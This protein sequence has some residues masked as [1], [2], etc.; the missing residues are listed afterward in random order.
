MALRHLLCV[1]LRVL[2]HLR[3]GIR[4]NWAIPSKRSLNWLA[5]S[6]LCAGFLTAPASQSFAQLVQLVQVDPSEVTAIDSSRRIVLQ[7]NV[8]P[9]LTAARDLGPVD[10]ALPLDHMLLQL[11]RSPARQAALDAYVAGL[12]DKSSANYHRWLTPAEFGQRF[13]AAQEDVDRVTAWLALHGFSVNAVLPNRMVIDFSGNAG[14]VR[15]AFRTGMHA[16]RYGGVRHVANAADPSIPAA[17]AGAVAGIVS[18]HDFAPRPML[19]PRK[20][21]GSIGQR[22]HGQFTTS[23]YG[24]AEYAVTPA[25]LA[26]IYNLTPLFQAGWTGK[27]QTIAI[28]GNSDVYRAA[29]WT[30]FRSTFGLAGYTSGAFRQIHPAPAARGASCADPGAIPGWDEEPIL[31]AEYATAAAPGATVEVVSC[32]STRATNGNLIALVNLVNSAGALPSVLSVSYGNCEAAN[33]VAA[34]VAIA[35][36]YQQAAAEGISVFAAAGD[37]GAAFCDV[38]GSVATHGIGVNAWASTPY[39]VAVGG[40][41]FADTSSNTLGKYWNRSNTATGGSARSY[42]PEVPWDDSCASPVIASY[43][44][45]KTSFGTTGFCY[46][47]YLTMDAFQTT[48]AGSGGPSGCATGAPSLKF[49]VSGGCRGYVKPIWQTVLGNPKDNLRDLPDLALFAADGLWEHYF[50]YCNSN[51]MDWDSAPCN[52]KQPGTWAAG[53]GTSFAAPIMAGIQALVAQRW[54]RQGNPNPVYYKLA[55]A[56]FNATALNA[57][58][59]AAN[60]AASGSSCVF[61]DV[62]QGASAVNC[63]GALNCY[64]N[65]LTTAPSTTAAA[66]RSQ[67]GWDFATGLGSVNAANLVL[68]PAW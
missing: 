29:D 66:Y 6:V 5:V 45:F 11:Q 12:T 2:S 19:V 52:A 33:G 16:Y 34:N 22:A 46:F 62:T 49:A 14:E 38:G 40:T 60:G 36:A 13:G 68:N 61:H 37:G 20:A 48:I 8:R 42:I 65:V 55:A 21:L 47:D 9:E 35:A 15:E 54:G 27:G 30:T 24:E 57:T 59:N 17:L 4:S 18:L 56:Q 1:L 32:A 51:P 28:L 44:G 25:D 58:C 50:L 43:M 3:F 7:G 67:A 39:N 63:S 31:D 53:G 10:D 26:T 23:Y 41:D 64:S